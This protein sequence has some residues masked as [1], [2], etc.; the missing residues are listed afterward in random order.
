MAK[1]RR[2]IMDKLYYDPESPAGYAGEQALFREAKKVSKKKK[3]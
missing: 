1:L 3:N 2:S